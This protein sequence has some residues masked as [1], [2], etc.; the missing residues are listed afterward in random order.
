M[1]EPRLHQPNSNAERYG[2]EHHWH[3]GFPT[4]PSLKNQD[5]ESGKD[6]ELCQFGLGPYG[7]GCEEN[8]DAPEER[9]A[10]VGAARQLVRS[11][12]DDCDN[13]CADGVEKCLHSSTKTRQTRHKLTR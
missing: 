3:P 2:A 7:Y 11:N 10:L 6:K 5:D 12:R 4:W 9:I 8:K 1:P 13:C